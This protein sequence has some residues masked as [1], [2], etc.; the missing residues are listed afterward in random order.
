MSLHHEMDVVVVGF[1]LPGA[2]AAIEAATAGAR[3]RALAGRRV[4]PDLRTAAEAVGVE[5]LTGAVAHEL[6]AD[7]GQVTGVGYALPRR[8]ADVTCS[9]VV[10]A[11]DA[12]HWEFVGT[13]VW[14]ITRARQCSARPRRRSHL[15]LVEEPELAVR[16]WCAEHAAGPSAAAGQ[17]ALYVDESDGAVLTG[18]G[19]P[20]P[21][22]FAALP[23]RSGSA[24]DLDVPTVIAAAGRAG[25][26]AAQRLVADR[27]PHRSVG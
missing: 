20:V 19:Q 9:S 24:A 2:V 8:V 3:V 6:A 17:S 22:L 1:G 13:A 7:G 14:S 12:R 15:H 4:H 25:R 26:A 10:L 11:V 16:R 27:G 23:A 21:G 18:D 5:V